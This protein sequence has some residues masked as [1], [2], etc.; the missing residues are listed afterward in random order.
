MCS[1]NVVVETIQAVEL[2]VAVLTWKTPRPVVSSFQ[3]RFKLECPRERSLA[4]FEATS[5]DFIVVIIP[6]LWRADV[7]KKLA[8]STFPAF[9]KLFG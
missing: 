5:V 3:R 2:A 4:C 1:V 7:D 6:F 8:I 9:S